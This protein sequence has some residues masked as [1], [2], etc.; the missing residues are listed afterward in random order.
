MTKHSESKA[1]KI[2]AMLADGHKPKV[3]AAVLDV[4]V[5]Y[6]YGVK[7]SA[8]QKVKAANKAVLRS[9]QGKLAVMRGENSRMHAEAMAVT[10]PHPVYVEVP[11]PQPFYHFSFWQ[12]LRILFLGRAA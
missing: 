10:R 7:S 5:T 12:R 4:S 6:V 9:M 2:R 11:V 3:V 8:K 1:A